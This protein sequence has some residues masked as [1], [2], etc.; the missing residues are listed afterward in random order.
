MKIV[1]FAPIA[2]NGLKQRPQHI[3]ELLSLKH[4]IWYIEPTISIMKYVLKGGRSYKKEEY[5]VNPNLHIIK[6]NGRFTAHLSLQAFDYLKIN[7]ISEKSQLKKIIQ[8]SDIIWVG[9]CG[10]YDLIVNVKNKKLV[11]DKMD[12]D[13]HITQNRFL[14][15]LIQ[16]VEPKL[17]KKA[18]IVFVTAINFYKELS[19][20][21]KSVYYVPNAYNEELKL[22][23]ECE[24]GSN[25]DKIIYGYVGT[26]AHWFDLK[27]IDVILSANER[28]YVYLIGPNHIPK[29]NHKR[30]KY[31]GP[32]TKDK[33]GGYIN[34]FNVCLYPF[35]KNDFLDTIDPVKIYEY[36][37][38]NKPVIA[39]DS[40]ETKK[41]ESLVY[42]YNN[43]EVLNALS[44]E[45][46]KPPFN[47][48]EECQK[49]LEDNSWSNRVDTI[50]KYISER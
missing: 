9:Y 36:L 44:I 31:I 33:I 19:S 24:C 18:D 43:Y 26:I 50:L 10:W 39:V 21:K 28:N 2:Y 23:L 13:A 8:N 45:K 12:D 37:A 7:T 15:K 34:L 17:I 30:V 29:L 48:K 5:N 27:A 3:A 25:S 35:I 32:V 42:R 49:Y 38:L 14:R 40:V 1:Y 46:L 4:E 11:Y 6:L 16:K 41:F 22:N 20:K 47:T